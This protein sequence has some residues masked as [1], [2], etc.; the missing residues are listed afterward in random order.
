MRL[1]WLWLWLRLLRL[2]RCL[3]LW[4]KLLCRGWTGAHV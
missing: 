3:R 1:L 4:V 2:C